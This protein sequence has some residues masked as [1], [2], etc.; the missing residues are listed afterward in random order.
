M[1]TDGR[2]VHKCW[3]YV[4]WRSRA[5]PPTR[6]CSDSPRGRHHGNILPGD[7]HRNRR[8]P[9]LC[10]IVAFLIFITN[11]GNREGEREKKI[12]RTGKINYSD[13]TDCERKSHK[14]SVAARRE[15]ARLI[16]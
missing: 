13:T 3:A 2:G 16:G 14:S 4:L 11:D 15:N 6:W 8:G 12:V 1:C 7:N 5:V 10:R 9:V